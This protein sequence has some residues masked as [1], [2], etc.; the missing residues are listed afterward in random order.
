MEPEKV[1]R[2]SHLRWVPVAAIKVSPNAQRKFRT[3]KAERIA[4]NFDVDKIGTPIV[5]HRDGHYWVIDGQHRVAA[6]RLMGWDDQQVQCDVREGLDER[7]EAELFDGLNDSLRVSVLD[8]FLIRCTAH[9]PRE[10]DIARTVQ[11]QGLRIGEGRDDIGCVSALGKVY[12]V[13]GPDRL[14]MALRIIRDA[15][16]ERGMRAEVVEGMGL[17]AHRYNGQIDEAKAVEKLTGAM[18]GMGGLLNRASLIKR[19][20][21][22]PRGHC[23]A[24]AIVETLNAGRGGKKLPD[25]WQ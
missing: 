3:H 20:L 5:S 23:V 8:R 9:R 24:A 7:A 18:G 11:A 19:Q 12:D 22:R 2:T 17:V 16:G 25:W 1:A 15:Y 4:A 13:A 6:L 10:C 21:G 14:G